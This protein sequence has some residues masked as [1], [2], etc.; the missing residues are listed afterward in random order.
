MDSI[1]YRRL[2]GSF[3]AEGTKCVLDTIGY[4]E[5]AFIIATEPWYIEFSDK[6]LHDTICYTATA[7][8][9]SRLTSLS[10]APD[11]IAVYKMPVV[12]EFKIN[13]GELVIALDAIQDPGNLGTIVRIA[14]WFGIKK[15]LCGNGTADIYS[16]KAVMATM[17]AISRVEMYYC[18]LE[19][20]LQKIK[21]QLTIYGT[22][23]NGNNV[24]KTE[25]TVGGIIVM[26]NE[27]RGVSDK[28]QHLFDKTLTIP[29]YPENTLT[30][31][32]LNVAIAT[33]IIVSQFRS[34]IL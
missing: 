4:F 34:R 21:G 33:G 1:K 17:G 30:S 13:G 29:S 6:I 15:I 10:T 2:E 22:M 27:G 12:E 14:D 7:E 11:V 18:N 19:H 16:P 20:E 26:G 28:I 8:D 24:F 5:L 3:K 25:L 23:L 31:E 9:M 32:S